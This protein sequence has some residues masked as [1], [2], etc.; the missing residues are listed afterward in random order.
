MESKGLLIS[1]FWLEE[2]FGEAL[3]SS[4]LAFNGSISFFIGSGSS[5]D[6]FWLSGG[7]FEAFE[8]LSKSRSLVFWV[9]SS[10]DCG[11]GDFF[12]LV[13]VELVEESSST[14]TAWLSV[15]SGSCAALR[16]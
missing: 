8:V 7:L 10:I 3:V 11:R 15:L 5:G 6:R 12:C 14:K 16:E 9:L 1:C 13:F 4:I 2:L